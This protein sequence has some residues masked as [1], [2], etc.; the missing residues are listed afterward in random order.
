MCDG[1]VVYEDGDWPSLDI[2]RIKDQV[3]QRTERIIS[4]L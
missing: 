4:E 2:E 3:A 1:D